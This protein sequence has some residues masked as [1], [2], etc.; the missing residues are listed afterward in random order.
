MRL[1]LAGLFLLLI[2]AGV[3][4]QATGEVQSIGFNGSYRPNCWTPLLVRLKPETVESGNYQLQVWQYDL[5]G[6]RPAYTRNIVLNGSEQAAEQRFWMYFLPQPIHEGLPDSTASLRDLQKDLQVFLCTTDGKRI[7]KLPLTSALQNVDPVRK[8][9]AIK[10]RG[11]K[12]ILSVSANGSKQPQIGRYNDTIGLLQDTDWVSLRMQELPEN[13]IGYEAVD[14]I[15]WL[16]GNPDDLAAGNQDTLAAIKDYVRFGGQLV[17]CQ[18]TTDYNQDKSFG[19]LLPVDLLKVDTKTNFDPLKSLAATKDEVPGLTLDESWSRAT[20][21]FQMVRATPRPGTVVNTW[22]DWKQDGS[23]TDVTPYL[24]RK[25]YGLGQVTWV[26]QPLTVDNVPANPTGWPHVWNRVFGWKDNSF[27]LPPGL[28][29]DDPLVNDRVLTYKPAGPVD[30]GFKMVQGLNLDSKSAWLIF[31]AVVFFLIYWLIAGPGTYAY[32]AAKKKQGLSWMFFSVSALIAIGVTALV[33]QLVLRGPPQLK[34][35]SFVRAVTG[36]AVEIYSRFGLYIPN[37]NNQNIELTDNA[38]GTVSYVSPFAEH[39][40]QLGDVSEFP[41][42]AEYTVPVRD[43]KSDTPAAITVPYRSS[44]KKFQS[45]WVGDLPLKFIGSPKLDPEDRRIPISGSL[46]N[47]TGQNLSEVYLAFKLNADQDWMIYIPT[48]DKNLT[49]DLKKDLGKP[50]FVGKGNP[51]LGVPTQGKILSDEL[52]PVSTS[53]GWQ[54]FWFDH[55]HRSSANEDPNVDEP[56]YDYVFPMLSVF[57]RLPAMKN[58]RGFSNLANKEVI[59]EDRVELF[60]RGAR[61][62]D[63]SSSINSGQLVILASNKGPLPTPLQIDGDK[64]TGDGTTFYQFI[65]PIDRGKA[66]QPTTRK[67]E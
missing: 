29:P 23:N 1:L 47:A 25:A 2:P 56:S 35:V 22:I 64:I 24:A 66:D 5:D 37:T 53:N 9:V 11:A 38:A 46:T 4:A 26:A 28:A 44:L 43:L 51:L 65:M 54:S 49:Y 16:D 7:A 3:F 13:P 52:T 8:D 59:S 48:W 62:L 67:A 40:Q 36:Q 12:L 34:H 57:D 50:L 18:S 17:I 10:P 58:N 21:P 41:S 45:R 19:D 32:L 30:L 15:V 60:N 55:F 39:P 42:P 31:V 63:A 27:V 14:A 61:M 6:D 20:G 33:V